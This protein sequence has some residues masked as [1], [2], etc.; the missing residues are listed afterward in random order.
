MKQLFM[1]FTH[2]FGNS[3]NYALTLA[4]LATE[5]NAI[6]RDLVDKFFRPILYSGKVMHS[7]VSDMIDYN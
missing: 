4:Q 2:E 1:S 6:P 5:D 7:T 3:L